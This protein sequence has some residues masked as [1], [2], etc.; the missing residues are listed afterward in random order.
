MPVAQSQQNGV[1]TV[2]VEFKEFGVI[3]AF[4]PTVLDDG[5]I[6]LIVAPEVSSIDNTIS[7]RLSAITIPGLKVRRAKTTLELHD[8]ESFAMAGLIQQDFTD[9]VRQLPLLGNIPIIGNLF[10][11]S[12]FKRGETELVIIVTPRRVRPQTLDQLKL[13]TDRVHAPSDID[14]LLNG[15]TADFT[16]APTAAPRR[17]NQANHA[18]ATKPGGID[19]DY[20]H[21]VR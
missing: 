1:P 20:G 21:I 13:P 4:T 7:V 16:N 12:N 18:D 3:L 9:T 17:A 15:K 14:L 8:G 2:S 11:S 5:T 10:R 19:G 6:S